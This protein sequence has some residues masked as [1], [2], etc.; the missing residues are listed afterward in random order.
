MKYF[1]YKSSLCIVILLSV[2]LLIVTGCSTSISHDGGKYSG[3]LE[4]GIPQGTG[5]WTGPDGTTYEGE[6]ENGVAH[7]TGTMTWP[8]GT[9]YEGEWKDGRKHGIGTYTWPDGSFTWVNGLMALN[10]AKA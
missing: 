4:N 2:S 10:M 3:D 7:G 6:F 1:S 9:V 5:K 8:D